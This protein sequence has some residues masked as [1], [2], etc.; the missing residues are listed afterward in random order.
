MSLSTLQR[1]QQYLLGNYS[2]PSLVLERGEGVYVY[3]EAGRRYLDFGSG[4]AVTAIGHSHPEWVAAVTEQAAKLAHVS[5]L[6][7]NR[8]QGELAQR[9]VEYAGDGRVFF[10]NSGTEA[11]EALIKLARLHGKRRTGVDGKCHKIICA[12]NAFHGRTFGGM[13]ATPQ[14][15]I[16]QGFRPML[17]GFSFATLNDLDSFTALVDAQTCAIMV[18]TIQ[19]EGGIHACNPGFLRG[20]RDLCDRH[21]LL[22]MLDEVQCGIGRSGDFFAYQSA[23]ILPDAIGMAK[24]LGGGF[25]IGAIWVDQARSDLFSAGSHGST[26]GGGPLACAAALATLNVIENEHL[27]QRVVDSTPAW[28]NRLSELVREFPNQL[29][30]V[31]GRGYMTGLAM[32]VEPGP[33]AAKLREAGLLTVPAGSRTLRL[34]PPLIAGAETLDQATDIIHQCLAE[35]QA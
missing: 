29:E 24:G 33:F 27:M 11:N 15:K 10:C 30:A 26:F 8:C 28:H 4:I 19:G 21:D 17:D 34:M 23:G 16:Q 6:F 22:L 18:E 12:H 7:A 31:R 32:K 20:L 25:P 13:S 1:Y 9:L 35:K 2:A 5:N 14:E 3:D